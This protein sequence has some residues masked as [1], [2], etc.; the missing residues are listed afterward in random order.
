[1][2]RFSVVV[3]VY[4]VE[5][6]LIECLESIIHQNTEGIEVIIV[7]DGSTDGSGQICKAYEAA[8]SAIKYIRQ[9]NAGLGAARNVGFL[10]AQGEYVIFLDSDDYWRE[11]CVDKLWE[12][13]V[14][15]PFLDIVYFDAEVVCESE[16]IKH[17]KE[18][19]A[20]M[21]DRKGKVKERIYRGE[22]FFCETYPEYFNVS[23]CMAAY[24]RK[25]LEESGI[26]FPENVLYEDNLFSLKTALKADYVAYLPQKL[27]VRRY[28]AD[29]IMTRRM[30][31]KCILDFAKMFGMVMDF[32]EKEKGKHE[33]IVFRKI[34]DFSCMRAYVFLQKYSEYAGTRTD[35]L[36]MKNEVCNRV[37]TLLR[38]KERGNLHLEEWNIWILIGQYLG[39]DRFV[40]EGKRGYKAKVEEK[41]KELPF[42]RLKKVGIYGGGKH[43][44]ELLLEARRL[45]PI[46]AEL[47]VI[48]SNATSG[49]YEFE[50]LPVMNIHDVPIDSEAVVISSYLYEKEMYDMAVKNLP[51]HME[52]V[53]LY[54]NEIRE[55]CWGWIADEG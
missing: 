2:I 19:D 11:D 47:F 9:E 16:G 26:C 6:Y 10:H 4:N 1:M 14:K 25:F 39:D 38:Q 43:T 12:C 34:M 28:R 53:K 22:E 37:I 41:I 15:H 17:D 44:R 8:Y 35:I 3:P 45:G 50:G 27:Y 21:Y 46:P 48:D 51:E 24:R 55:L 13:L 30:D 18:Y 31:E 52:I 7:D 20:R 29:S 32:S 49:E 40:L 54:Q 5:Q 23:A 33:E 36:Q 42:F